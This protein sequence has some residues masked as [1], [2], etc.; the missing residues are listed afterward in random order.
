MSTSSQS[1]SES[2]SAHRG[3]PASG[4]RFHRF[5]RFS[6]ILS[7]TLRDILD[8]RFLNE[9]SP[10]PLTRAQFCFLKLIA[11]NPD[12][13][14]GEVARFLGVSSAAG[15]KNVDKLERYGLVNRGGS[16]GDRRATVL[17]ASNAGR[18]LVT[19]YERLKTSR[20]APVIDAMGPDKIDQLCDLLE[21]VCIGLLEQEQPLEG[22]CLRCSGYYQPNC[23][24]ESLQGVCALNERRTPPATDSA[25]TEENS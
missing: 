14:V 2:R 3:S 4:N 6:H 5:L 24:V 8:E 10:H 11:L 21:Q 20:I 9:V 25:G 23:S 17:K 15:S 16:P 22:S 18:R 1:A 12:L 7:S 19:D 13:Q